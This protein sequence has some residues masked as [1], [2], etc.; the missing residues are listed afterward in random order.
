MIVLRY[1]FNEH[2]INANPMTPEEAARQKIDELLT[3]AGWQIQDFNDLNLG[4]ALGVVVREFP[5]ESG[6]ADYLL[7]IDREAVGAIEAKP[8]G[9]TL[10]GVEEQT[11][12]YLS[13]L[14]EGIPHI[15]NPLPFG[16]ESTGT[17]TF[18]VDLRDPSPRSR[19]VF[20][21]HKPDTL[22]GWLNQG[23]TLRAR[24][25]GLPALA[26]GNLRDCQSEAITNLEQSFAQ[27][28]PRS[29]IQM[30][31]GSG[32][33]F[34]AVSFIYRLIKFGNARRVLFLVD[35][36]TLGEQAL[37][38]FKQYVTPD[39]GR[40][41]TELYNV[42]HLTS[43][44]LDPVSRVC[45]TT[46]QRL[47]SML[48]GDEE[49]DTEI[50]EQS[51][52]DVT[53]IEGQPLD[54]TYNPEIPV[55]TFDFVITDE[56]HRSIYNLWRQVLEYFDAFLVGM[57]ATP[58]K[59]TLGFFNQNLV[60]EYNHE[61]AVADGV[62]VGYEVYRIKTE[63]SERGSKVEAGYYIDIRDKLTREKRWEMLDEDLEYTPRQLDR[64]VV[65]TDQIRTVIRTF[66]E[67][68]PEIFPERVVVPKTLI[69]AKDDSHAEDIVRI[70]REEFNKGNDFCK[71]ITYRTQE[72]SSTL[73][74][75]FR[76]S[77]N[78]RIAVT[79]DMIS[80]GTDI[81]PL[82]CLIFMR[83]VKSQVYF[84]QMKGRG[85]R[86]ISPTDLESVT[87]GARFKTHFV[88]VDAVG[89]C[90]RD[91]TDTRPL[92]QK[93]SVS[94]EKLVKS[95]ALGVR[96][97]KT[98]TTLAGR[99]ARLDR[100]LG[101]KDRSDLKKAAGE[102]PMKQIMN[103]L[104]DAV[105]PDKHQAKAKEIFQTEKPGVEQLKL[106]AKELA[107]AAC[108]PFDNP[109]FRNALIDIKKRNEQ[110]IDELSK[111][112]VLFAGG[113]AGATERAHR[114][115]DSFKNFIEE[116]KDELTALQII[117]G[118]PYGKRRLTYEEIKQLAEAIEKPP[119]NL[120]P[121]LVWR[122]Y[123]YLEKSKVKGA[124]PQKLLTNIISLVRFALGESQILV[125]FTQTVEERFRAWLAVQEQT[126]Q[127]FT[128][129][130]V[131]WLEMLKEHI[132]T[133]LRIDMNVLELAPFYERGG[134][135]KAYRLFG[136]GLNGMLEELNEALA[137]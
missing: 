59:Q 30:A 80:T 71:K 29:L 108:L 102:R 116:N 66:K 110:I 70:V 52:F 25:R 83:D 73:I 106:A 87:P 122:A 136:P 41:F 24:L 39:D 51:L 74:A 131:E 62:N 14:P 17:E 55:E 133:S 89:V 68:L 134:P 44:T 67:K 33:T 123:E 124:G 112:R 57:T 61:R 43:N 90:E 7:F 76:N 85:T 26:A 15:D 101:D 115:T 99:L 121:D 4:A 31:T 126:G 117:Y 103:D 107:R 58:S 135:V 56:C 109:K 129:E 130:Q 92:E 72:K 46:I 10:S 137:G 35:R 82:E 127:K 93:K 119:Y 65:A 86:T 81:K 113:D 63:I 18:F 36:R 111:D 23:E 95:V 28:K 40:K 32:K 22:K 132:A 13:G 12:G 9:S 120:T 88:I 3:K 49:L 60:M 2:G 53:P 79:V 125:P 47:Y 16:Y 98:L 8:E 64:N 114:I 91:K 34:A 20:A 84:E 11:G 19:R 118:K 42:Q 94:F 48:R 75:N 104:L 97:E 27:G 21:F 6:F 100:E 37:T 54:I 96:S 105:D 128:P 5:L 1:I 45:I 50:E 77:P 69:F 38:E 78:P